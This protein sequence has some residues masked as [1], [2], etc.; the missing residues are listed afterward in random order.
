MNKIIMNQ[1][2]TFRIP[3]EGATLKTLKNAA[4]NYINNLTKGETQMKTT[5]LLPPG[6][7]DQEKQITKSE[8]KTL[9]AEADQKG[10]LLS[11]MFNRSSQPKQNQAWT[12]PGVEPLLPTSVN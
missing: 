4:S 3:Q 5:P 2:H 6:V 12:G 8:L 9:Q 11:T 1:F 7:I 10:I